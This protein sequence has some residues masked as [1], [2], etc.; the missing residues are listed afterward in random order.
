MPPCVLR[1]A[2]DVV[3]AMLL[4]PH[5]AACDRVL[6]HPTAGPICRECWDAIVRLHPPL[7][8]ACG[9]ALPSWRILSI[10]DG[11]C[12]ACRRRG[13][14]SVNVGRSVGH[15]AGT[16]ERIVRAHKYQGRRSV[17]ERLGPLLRDAGQDLLRDAAC[18]VPVPLHPFRRFT[19]GFNQAADLASTTCLPLV[20]ALWRVRATPAQAGLRARVRRR[21][22]AGAF[23][24]SAWLSTHT[25]QRYLAGR[26]VVLVDDVWTTGATLEACAQVLRAAGVREVRALTVARAVTPGTGEAQSRQPRVSA[27]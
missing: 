26:A 10:A 1:G 18:A 20:H 7:C 27:G 25:R 12:P 19:R 21:N 11:R 24:L 17:A 8:H 22:V 23:R 2:A 13:A 6:A 16:L 15:Y 5:C 14:G 3:L 4:A 9:D